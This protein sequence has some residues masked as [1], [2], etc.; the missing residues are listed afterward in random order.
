MID[1]AGRSGEAVTARGAVPR[2]TLARA[3]LRSVLLAALCLAPPLRAQAPPMAT[4]PAATMIEEATPDPISALTI[5]DG[6]SEN[7][8]SAIAQDRRGFLWFGTKDGLDR[9]DG[10]DF[11]AF[12][13][14]P[15]T[16]S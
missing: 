11:L 16:S 6:L 4:R 14:D 15:A 8:V 10:Y 3:V 7:A 5:A 12:R 9:Y 13:H 2:R 1:T